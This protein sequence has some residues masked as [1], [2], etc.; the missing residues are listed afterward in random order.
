MLIRTV[1]ELM[2]LP[3]VASDVNFLKI[4][5]ESSTMPK[6]ALCFLFIPLWL[7]CSFEEKQKVLLVYLNEKDFK[8]FKRTFYLNKF[9]LYPTWNFLSQ[10]DIIKKNKF[11]ILC[12]HGQSNYKY[13][14]QIEGNALSIQNESA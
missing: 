3:V 8:I 12:T 2:C 4:C 14:M 11:K 6:Y 10:L 5:S 9:P 13:E 7:L 1:R